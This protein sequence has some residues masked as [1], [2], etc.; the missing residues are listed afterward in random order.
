MV[1]GEY[2]YAVNQHA[3]SFHD[4]S[5]KECFLKAHDDVC[6]LSGVWY[7]FFER[8]LG[9]DNRNRHEATQTYPQSSDAYPPSSQAY[10]PPPPPLTPPTTT[11]DTTTTT[12]NITTDTTTTTTDTTTITTNTAWWT[13]N[14]QIEGFSWRRNKRNVLLIR[15]AK[16]RW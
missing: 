7:G 13:P 16:S 11:N 14:I 15:V 5:S 10:P 6:D 12:I 8:T 3:K 9:W 1:T 4:R 2:K